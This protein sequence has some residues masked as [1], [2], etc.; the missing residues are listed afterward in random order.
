MLDVSP[1]HFNEVIIF[2]ASL[3]AFMHFFCNQIISLSEGLTLKAESKADDLQGVR[4]LNAYSS[5]LLMK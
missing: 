5:L 4:N 1:A 2:T 3:V